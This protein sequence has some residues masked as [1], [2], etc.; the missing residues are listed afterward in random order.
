M[1]TN[2]LSHA[3]PFLPCT[4]SKACTVTGAWTGMCSA[5]RSSP[6][7]VSEDQVLASLVRGSFSHTVSPS[8]GC[9]SCS[10]NAAWS[11]QACLPAWIPRLWKRGTIRN[12]SLHPDPLGKTTVFVLSENIWEPGILVRKYR[13][14]DFSTLTENLQTLWGRNIAKGRNLGSPL[15]G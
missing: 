13:S 6:R 9:Q 1:N 8:A 14:G 15:K 2:A 12:A 5:Q 7:A 10:L 3:Y 11:E 4:P